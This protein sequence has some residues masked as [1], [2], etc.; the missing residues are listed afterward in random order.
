[1]PCYGYNFSSICPAISDCNGSPERGSDPL[2]FHVGGIISIHMEVNMM[3]STDFMIVNHGNGLDGVA[4]RRRVGVCRWVAAW[5]YVPRR[6]HRQAILRSVY[7][8]FSYPC[9]PFPFPVI[10]ALSSMERHR[11]LDRINQMHMDF[12]KTFSQISRPARLS[13][14]PYRIL[15]YRQFRPFWTCPPAT[16]LWW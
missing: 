7:Q 13:A 4:R 12:F 9:K 1:M 8:R 16:I 11:R 3:A 2:L 15:G 14:R 10:L 6:C 5:R